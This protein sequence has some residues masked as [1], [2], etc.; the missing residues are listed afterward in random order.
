VWHDSPANVTVAVLSNVHAV[1]M[2]AAV[3][4]MLA[5]AMP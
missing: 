2:D 5:A 1:R 4:R 3:R